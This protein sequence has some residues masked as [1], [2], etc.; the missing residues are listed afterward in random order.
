MNKR[1]VLVVCLALLGWSAVASA[2][3]TGGVKG[4][5]NFANMTFSGGTGTSSSGTREAW[6][7]GGFVAIPI[8]KHVTI[9]PEGLISLKGS[10]TTEIGGTATVKFT[11][12]DVPVLVRFDIPTSR[13]VVP[14]LYGGP[15]LGFLLSAKVAAV[16]PSGTHEEDV[17]GDM[18]STELGIAAG[19]GLQFGRVLVEARYVQGLTNVLTDAAAASG[20]TLRNRVIKVIGGVRF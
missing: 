7:A 14:Y 13:R 5:L 15:N 12:F 1:G 6:M 4:G 18:R 9:Q 3:V 8:A 19:G 2:Q 17:K 20:T 11:Y 16:T 10:E